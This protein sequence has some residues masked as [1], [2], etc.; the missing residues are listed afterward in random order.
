MKRVSKKRVYIK[1]ALVFSLFAMG[2][3]A[4]LGTG[5]SLAWFSDT[6]PELNNIFHF[7]DFELTVSHR[8]ENGTWEKV[9]SDTV[10][11]DDQA[12]YEPGYTQVVYLKIKNTGTREFQYKAAVSTTDFVMATNVF[13]Q[14]FNLQ[15]YLKFGLICADTEAAMDAAVADRETAKAV[16]VTDLNDYHETDGTAVL[17]PNEEAFVAL[18]VRMPEDVGNVANYRGVVKPTVDLCLI[19]TADQVTS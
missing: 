11:F 18:V 9:Q 8:L 19:V 13:G 16:S 7:A 2:V 15:E 1:I 5:T 10:V 3:W 17:M 12:L 14:R 4:L 6:S